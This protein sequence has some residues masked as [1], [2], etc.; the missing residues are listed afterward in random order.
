MAQLCFTSFQTVALW[1]ALQETSKY[2]NEARN[3]DCLVGLVVV[4]VIAT[5]PELRMNLSEV[6]IG[7]RVRLAEVPS[8]QWMFGVD[9]VIIGTL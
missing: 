1:V 9:V 2:Q 7:P 6:D 5:L 8:A 3:G 4:T